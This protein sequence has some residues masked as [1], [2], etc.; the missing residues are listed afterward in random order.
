M[1]PTVPRLDGRRV[2]VTRGMGEGDP[3]AERLRALGAQV[4]EFPAIALA[5]PASYHDLDRALRDLAGF[6]VAA[7][8]SANAVER[9]VARMDAIGIARENLAARR[10]AAVGPAT[11]E[12]LRRAVR[13]ADFV[14]TAWSGEALGTALKMAV[15]GRRILV[16]RAA[17]G[18][19]EL[20]E[21]LR[22]AGAEVTAPDAYQT[23]P[24]PP[25]TLRPLAD[26]IERAEVDAVAFASP[27]A[28]RSVA[29]ALG[30]RVA[31]LGRVLVAAIG[32]TTADAVREAGWTV[33][34]M[35]QRPGAAE[36]A[37][38]IAERLGPVSGR[39]G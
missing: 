14:P 38:A 25:E 30:D 29:A 4:L 20:V 26:R 32:T 5:P 28:V 23:V 24:A 19:P 36:L 39:P 6:D 15:R 2:A 31:L 17:G 21:I 22:A 7:F 10:L 37:E 35:P 16:P 1:T 8:A 27:S 3:L 18:R 12:A 9:T 13:A 33:G 11:A 34:A